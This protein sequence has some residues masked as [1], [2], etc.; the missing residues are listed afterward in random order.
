MRAQPHRAWQPSGCLPD[1]AGSYARKTGSYVGSAGSYVTV[2]GLLSLGAAVLM[3]QPA[4]T[5]TPAG[6][7]TETIPGSK[8]TFEM[9]AVPGGT[10]K[11]G[12][13]DGEAGRDADEGP[14][15]EVTLKPFWIDLEAGVWR[16]REGCRRADRHDLRRTRADG[17][18][19]GGWR[20]E[21][22]RTWRN[23]YPGGSQ[24]IASAAAPGM[25]GRGNH[26]I[27]AGDGSCRDDPIGVD[28]GL[29]SRADRDAIRP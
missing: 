19:S 22:G 2:L 29:R 15:V 11:L 16:Q 1:K 14:Q 20:D 9:V 21:R 26:C 3:A 6:S 13:P 4:L 28:V 10:F 8:V 23:R 24:V 18:I 17:A 12:S 7:Y 25:F 5:L 27:E